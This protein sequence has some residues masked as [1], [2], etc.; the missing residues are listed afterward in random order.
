MSEFCERLCLGAR[1]VSAR[2]NP[3]VLAFVCA[4]PLAVG[5]A[6]TSA[7]SQDATGG[8][9][10][11]EPS[12]T[13]D[14]SSVAVTH[15][16]AVPEG[17]SRA[18]V[19]VEG[20]LN[21]VAPEAGAGAQN[22][23]PIAAGSQDG[24]AMST[25]ARVS[26][27]VLGFAEL[28]GD[29]AIDAGTISIPGVGR[30]DVS[31]KTIGQLESDLSQILGQAFRRDIA[32]S[33]E[34]NRYN[35]Y[36]VTGQVAQPGEIA[37]RPGLTLIQA[38]A[39]AGGEQSSRFGAGGLDASV[40]MQQTRTQLRHALAQ[41]ERL[42]A[43][44]HNLQVVKTSER[45]TSLDTPGMA[46]ADALIRRQN[47]LLNDR[48][49]IVETQLEGL[50][51]EHE[52]AVVA[53]ET[54]KEQSSSIERQLVLAREVL[55]GFKTLK[56]KKLVSNT[57]YLEQQRDVVELEVR[58]AEI[59]AL[60]ETS[61]SRVAEIATRMV[62]LRQQRLAEINDRM[63]ALEREIAQHDT[64]LSS[65]GGGG[66]P[67]EGN[68]TTVME[69]NIARSN[70]GVVETVPAHVF[71]QIQPGDVIIVSPRP[72][73]TARTARLDGNRLGSLPDPV[74]AT[75]TQTERL[76]AAATANRPAGARDGASA[77]AAG[78]PVRR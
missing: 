17:S 65:L 77:A 18:D 71:T 76:I 43:E 36:F 68:A 63:E 47:E 64:T 32:V 66:A 15:V 72:A 3:V 7:T 1:L 62:S 39:L 2:F 14:G 45:L 24:V 42:N 59:R 35:P 12:T 31:N 73:D 52:T 29:Y 69:Y 58:H 44:K 55:E 38:I 25:V 30:F 6:P 21:P 10:A 13:H 60:I 49:N 57:R 5:L 51:T 20:A 34:I 53:F 27:R 61:R 46:E 50:R 54:T 22:P 26:L 48:R 37:W 8:N 9:A 4:V 78:G 41:M 75:V 11:G 19:A 33:A 67:S 40:V 28:N 74:R 56:D 23:V 70:K 16:A